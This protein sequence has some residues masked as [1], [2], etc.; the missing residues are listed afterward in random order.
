[1]DE[2]QLKLAIDHMDQT[3][4]IS[5]EQKQ[6]LKQLL[7]NM[8]ANPNQEQWKKSQETKELPVLEDTNFS[9]DSA[10][11]EEKEDANG[12][13]FKENPEGDVQEYLEGDH[14]WQQF[15][16]DISA[17]RE[18]IKAGKTLVDSW[19]TYENILHQKY[20]WNYQAFVAGEKMVFCGWR[21]PNGRFYDI[22][23]GF[24]LRCADGSDFLGGREEWDSYGWNE[25]SGF[26]VRCVKN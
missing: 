6:S 26:S 2:K 20:K 11:R 4:W 13:K 5:A 21:S 24:A 17:S 9:I 12:I 25:D 1:M 19:Q 16:T 14:K 15:F 8:T 23:K 7:I 10:G 22:D 18:A 3:P